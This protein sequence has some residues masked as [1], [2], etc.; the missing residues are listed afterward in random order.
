LHVK[1]LMFALQ[2]SQIKHKRKRSFAMRK[3][4]ISI[5]ISIA[6]ILGIVYENF[7]LAEMYTQSRGKNRALFG[8]IELA[9]YDV[10][11]YLGMALML[12]LIFAF[13]A[14]HKKENYTLSMLALILSGIGLI[15]LFVR[16]WTLLV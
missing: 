4:S 14:F 2:A 7:R 16:F 10:K 6:G 11:L 8:L 9:Q 15:L 13:Q 1:Q 12:N 5:G 3:Y